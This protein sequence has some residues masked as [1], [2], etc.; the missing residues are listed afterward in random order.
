MAPEGDGGADFNYSSGTWTYFNNSWNFLLPT[1]TITT[2]NQQ[3]LGGMAYD[4]ST[5]LI[6]YFGGSVDPSETYQYNPKTYNWAIVNPD[7]KPKNVFAMSMAYIPNLSN[8]LLSQSIIYGGL[9]GSTIENQ[10]W[11]YNS[12]SNT[13]TNLAPDNYPPPLMNYSMAYDPISTLVILFGG[14]LTTSVSASSNQTWG[15]D[16]V[17]NTWINLTPQNI[18]SIHYPSGRSFASLANSPIGLIL[19]GGAETSENISGIYVSTLL[20][21]TWQC[22]VSTNTSP[23]TVTWTQL[24][25]ATSPPPLSSAG[26]AYDESTAQVILYGGSPGPQT[27]SVPYFDTWAFA[28][29]PPP[30]P[31]GTVSQFLQIGGSSLPIRAKTCLPGMGYVNQVRWS[32]PSDKSRI[33][34]YHIFRNRKLT[35]KIAEISSRDRLRFNDYNVKPC[36]NYIYYIVSVDQYGNRSKPAIG[37]FREHHKVPRNLKHRR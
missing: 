5:D 23:P 31:S 6:I 22:Q 15:Y 14:T 3:E 8:P 4:S 7:S 16:S 21:D 34:A 18:D 12:N 9:S 26:M 10:T 35:K 11:G 20:N 32:A 30:S 28:L 27:G 24:F 36:K 1:T 19:F 17:Q 29:V 2:T 37:K 13:W 25:P 33:V